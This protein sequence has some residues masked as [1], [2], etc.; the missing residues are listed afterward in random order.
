MVSIQII[1]FKLSITLL[2]TLII[3]EACAKWFFFLNDE[4]LDIFGYNCE[5]M[6][7]CLEVPDYSINCFVILV[8]F[9]F[10]HALMIIKV[11]NKVID[12]LNIKPYIWMITILCYLFCK[13]IWYYYKAC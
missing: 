8:H 1:L 9:H 7:V 11:D 13:W 4:P 6:G 12:S 5:I 2:S 10:A 3:V